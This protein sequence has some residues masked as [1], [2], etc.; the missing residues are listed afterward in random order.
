M[1]GCENLPLQ[2]LTLATM[3]VL[4]LEVALTG[5]RMTT[6]NGQTPWSEVSSMLTS[7]FGTGLADLAKKTERLLP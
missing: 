1:D 5:R 6:V 3:V 2:F 7:F 4:R